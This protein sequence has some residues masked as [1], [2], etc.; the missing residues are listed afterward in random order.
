MEDNALAQDIA[1]QI[2]DLSRKIE[3]AKNHRNALEIT[4][5]DIE[6]FVARVTWALEHPSELLLKP[7]NKAQRH[8]YFSLMFE[9]LPTYQDIIDGTP[10][11]TWIFKL[12]DT[13]LPNKTE[14]VRR[15]GFEP[16]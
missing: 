13:Y 7:T 6:D 11:L 3:L 5:Q 15:V 16:T 4:E 12:N 1:G 10:K 8:S 9:E 14:L 2:K